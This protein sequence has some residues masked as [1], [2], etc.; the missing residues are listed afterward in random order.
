MS[1]RS[2]SLSLLV[3]ALA[4]FPVAAS[5]FIDMPFDA[6]ARGATLIV[7]G[8][9]G[10]VTSAWDGNHEVIYSTARVDVSRYFAGDGPSTL[11]V[12]EAGGTVGDYTQEAI[13]F[14]TVREGQEV[15]LLLERWDD[16]SDWRISAYNQGKYLVRHLNG[17]D[18]LVRDPIT[19]GHE[20]A[21]AGG[22]D[23]SDFGIIND[24]AGLPVEDFAVM[25]RAARTANAPDRESKKQ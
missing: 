9:V 10:P 11:V 14:P 17:Q 19:Q 8:T 2:L 12:R 13:G 20:N 22:R 25:V 15:V 16:S 4:T 18:L 23:V 3:F 6:V 24:D 21:R 5:Q 7:R 1:R